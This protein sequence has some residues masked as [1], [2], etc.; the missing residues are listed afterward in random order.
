[1]KHFFTTVSLMI[2]SALTLSYSQKLRTD[3]SLEVLTWNLEWFGNSGK[4][5]SDEKKQMQVASQIIKKLGQV[6][7]IVF[8]EICDSVLFKT[9]ADSTGYKYYL[10]P[11]SNTLQK[12]GIFH[13]KSLEVVEKPTQILPEHKNTFAQLPL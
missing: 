1:M 13:S 11:G 9:L 5:P 2:I 6:D 4:G 10:S 7:V 3:N 12:I 8:E